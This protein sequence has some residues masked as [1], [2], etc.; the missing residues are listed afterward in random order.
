MP[1]LELTR[2]FPK[3][4]LR[5]IHSGAESERFAFPKVLVIVKTTSAA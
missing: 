2:R 5:R 3:G 1:F 4:S